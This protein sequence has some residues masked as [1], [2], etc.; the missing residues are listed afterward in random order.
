[1]LTRKILAVVAVTALAVPVAW[2]QDATDLTYRVAGTI[3]IDEQRA[4]ALIESSA[5]TQQL[6]SLGDKIDDWEIV[7]IDPDEVT[8]GRDGQFVRLQ[9]EGKLAPLTAQERAELSEF[10]VTS[11]SASLD[12]DRAF[13]ALGKLESKPLRDD[14][15]PTY[16]DINSAL[17]LAAATRIYEID[18]ELA[19]SPMAVVQLS[20]VALAAENPFRLTVGENRSDEIY[21]LP[22]E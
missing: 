17:G 13:E 3:A 20:M 4:V 19:E 18:G 12:F 9:L 1:M 2:A 15:G 10:S 21:L 6:Y 7:A 22:S 5:G 16:A 11:G 14:S 8:F